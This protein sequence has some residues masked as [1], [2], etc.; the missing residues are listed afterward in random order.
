MVDAA[1]ELVHDPL[2]PDIAKQILR[3]LN[4]IIEIEHR[5]RRLGVAVN[6]VDRR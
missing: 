5:A 1:I 6:P 3:S 2:R 4:Q